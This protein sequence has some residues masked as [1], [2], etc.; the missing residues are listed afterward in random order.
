VLEDEFSSNIIPTVRCFLS[1]SHL[2]AACCVPGQAITTSENVKIPRRIRRRDVDSKES[3]G[4]GVYWIGA[5]TGD[6]GKVLH[7]ECCADSQERSLIHITVGL[8]ETQLYLDLI[9][10]LPG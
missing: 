4:E 3:R 2:A 5:C 8:L 1:V 6:A 10:L 7:S 9:L